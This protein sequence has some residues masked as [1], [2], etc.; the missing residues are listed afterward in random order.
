MALIFADGGRRQRRLVLTQ[1]SLYLMADNGYM[2]DLSICMKR[3]ISRLHQDTNDVSKRDKR[4]GKH[5][6]TK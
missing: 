3:W 4:I 1:S 6:A 5:V 2:H